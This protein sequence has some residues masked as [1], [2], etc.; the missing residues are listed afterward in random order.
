MWRMKKRCRLEALLVAQGRDHGG[1]H[2]G[3][4]VDN[5]PGACLWIVVIKMS[6]QF[7]VSKVP[8]SGAIV[9]CHRIE[10]AGHKKG[11]DW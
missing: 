8:Q 2:L 4:Q 7:N 9:L 5:L 1:K 11:V 3:S 6:K 10:P